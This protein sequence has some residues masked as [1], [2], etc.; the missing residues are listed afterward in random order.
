MVPVTG[1]NPAPIGPSSAPVVAISSGRIVVSPPS[2]GKVP[3]PAAPVVI[4]SKTTPLGTSLVADSAPPPKRASKT[5]LL[6]V[7]GL[8]AVALGVVG[9]LVIKPKLAQPTSPATPVTATES[10]KSAEVPAPKIPTSSSATIAPDPPSSGVPADAKS[11][12]L[13][14]PTA[15]NKSPVKPGDPHTM[16]KAPEPEPVVVAPAPAPEPAPAPP[17]APAP[18]PAAPSPAPAPA[19]AAFNPN[20]CKAVLGPKRGVSGSHPQELTLNGTDAA[21]SACARSSIKSAPAAPIAATVRLKFS[22]NRA[23]RGATCTGCTPALNQCIAASTGRTVSVSFK[24]GDVTG[25]PDFDVPVTFT[26]D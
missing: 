23:F 8:G 13:P 10:V 24:S 21:W 25:E 3:A 1:A 18:A 11:S 2:T 4:A 26:C 6:A 15:P 12:H 16:S 5:P 20:T 19:P 14:T 9:V 22:D 17:P 7:V